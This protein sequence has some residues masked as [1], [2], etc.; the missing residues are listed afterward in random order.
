MAG[1]VNGAS[2]NNANEVAYQN[3]QKKT[4]HAS[5]D[6]DQN[7]TVDLNEAKGKYESIFEN[8]AKGDSSTIETK[9]GTSRLNSG[10]DINVAK[11][12]IQKYLGG[13]TMGK[14]LNNWTGFGNINYNAIEISDGEFAGDVQS[15]IDTQIETAVQQRVQQYT[16]Q[17]TTQYEAALDKAIEQAENELKGDLHANTETNGA[18]GKEG[19]TKTQLANIKYKRTSQEIGATGDERN[20]NIAT[21]NSSQLDAKDTDKTK[22]YTTTVAF[23]E[24]NGAKAQ[25]KVVNGTKQ[26][27]YKVK[28][29]GKT[30]YVSV[31]DA[32]QVHTM[33][34]DKGFLRNSKYTTDD[35]IA[36]AKWQANNDGV[37]SND[38][39]GAKNVDVKVRKVDG[40]NQSV[41]TWE[42]SSGNEHSRV[43]DHNDV[44][45]LTS[46][47]D[48]HQV[49]APGTRAKYA[50][51][52]S[53][54]GTWVAADDK[55]TNKGVRQFNDDKHMV[56]DE[57]KDGKPSGFVR[58]NNSR[59][60]IDAANIGQAILNIAERAKDAGAEIT[61]VEIQ[62]SE[63]TYGWYEDVVMYDKRG[64]NY[65]EEGEQV[66][67]TRT[68]T[69][70]T[71]VISKDG[72]VSITVNGHTYTLDTK[73]PK[74]AD[75]TIRLI[76]NELT[77]QKNEE[78]AVVPELADATINITAVEDNRTDTNL[79]SAHQDE[80]WAK[81]GSGTV[82][83]VG[84][85]APKTPTPKSKG[86]VKINY[87]QGGLS[88]AQFASEGWA[89][90]KGR[91]A[92]AAV[93]KEMDTVKGDGEKSVRNLQNS[94][95]F[96]TR[97]LQALDKSCKTPADVANKYNVSK[98][99]DALE[100]ANPS[101]FDN[102]GTMFKN[103]D[104]NRINLP[105][106]D[107]LKR[108]LKAE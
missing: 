71:P 7:K 105:E 48:V 46:S 3:I 69:T 25:E 96:A 20:T 98:L 42:D 23:L 107:K 45:G 1:N 2:P 60:E 11:T 55:G 59:M 99:A 15:Q 92:E 17:I 13:T 27:I 76:E 83:N 72:K 16:S 4:V 30:Q 56:Q 40:Q 87:N 104:F 82:Q 66:Y 12:T 32:G 8:A 54:L 47:S 103:A 102:D 89:A 78:P 52:T 70:E 68:E 64:N 95:Q 53:G 43:I 61:G 29:E 6:G 106:A 24:A 73:D 58:T 22:G 81:G 80:K 38:F 51:E 100:T 26:T 28:I 94:E 5:A 21:F 34:R 49:N 57:V 93:L 67:R 37:D 31:D 63:K 44:T 36:D 18:N 65:A 86:V 10:V 33:D 85:E 35:S 74:A 77:M 75:R 88:R 62:K 39:K 79:A 19:L 9:I 14:L 84:V 97:L 90:S 108:Y 50:S 41:L 91:V 101:I